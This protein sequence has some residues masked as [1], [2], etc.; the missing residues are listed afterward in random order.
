[1]DFIIL[2]AL[3]LGIFSHAAALAPT[4]ICTTT[5]IYNRLQSVSLIRT[6]DSKNVK[7]TSLWN[8]G[9]LGVGAETAAIVFLRHF[10]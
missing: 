1:M 4:P 8:T 9:V 7:L 3:V 5:P 10:G 2:L 6:S